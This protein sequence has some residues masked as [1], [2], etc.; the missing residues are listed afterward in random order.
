MLHSF[1]L[2]IQWASFSLSW[3][4]YSENSL[5][6]WSIEDQIKLKWMF[7]HHVW[8]I[9]MVPAIGESTYVCKRNCRLHKQICLSVCTECWPREA[10]MLVE[11]TYVFLD[12]CFWSYMICES[13][14]CINKLLVG[15]EFGLLMWTYYNIR[16]VSLVWT[17]RTDRLLLLCT[18]WSI[19]LCSHCLHVTSSSLFLFAQFWQVTDRSLA[20]LLMRS[21]QF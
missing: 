1:G 20:S 3:S 21:W 17:F 6:V 5:A 7:L 19:F 11:R 16:P 13:L 4:L 9:F 15:C 18:A 14:R 8:F 10:S 12:L 2:I